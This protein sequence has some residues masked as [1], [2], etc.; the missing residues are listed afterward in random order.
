VAYDPLGDGAENNDTAAAAVDGDRST[1][2]ETERYPGPLAETK[3]GVGLVVTATG[4]ISAIEITGSPN[5]RYFLGWAEEPVPT[6]ADWQS[7]GSGTLLTG[8]TRHRVPV[9]EGVWLVWLTD[10][11]EQPDG[12][13]AATISDVSLIP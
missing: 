1:G 8:T 12:T 5:T 10:L 7:V 13:Y 6:P 3:A 11:P 2:W 4:P 9:S